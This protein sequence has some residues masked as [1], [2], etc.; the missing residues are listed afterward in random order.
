[1]YSALYP[2]CLFATALK[3]EQ[4]ELFTQWVISLGTVFTLTVLP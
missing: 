1:M 4:N 3:R 2:T